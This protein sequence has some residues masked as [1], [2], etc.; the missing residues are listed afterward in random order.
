MEAQVFKQRD[1]KLLCTITSKDGEFKIVALIDSHFSEVT[2]SMTWSC[3]SDDSL[4]REFFELVETE[5]FEVSDVYTEEIAQHFDG[6]Y[7]FT[8]ELVKENE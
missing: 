1:E 3:C 4:R 8:L 7:S 2:E 6:G 5:I